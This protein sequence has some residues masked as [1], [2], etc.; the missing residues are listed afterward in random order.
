V[1]AALA[2]LGVDELLCLGDVVGYGADPGRVLDTVARRASRVVAGNHDHASAGRM[3][4]GWFNPYARVAAEW[5]AE[6]LS[7]DQARYLEGLPL[8]AR[9][10]GATL[11]HSSP[12]NP[13]EWP[14]LVSP[15]DG[16]PAF[17]A[18]EGPLCF[19]GHSHLPAVWTRDAAGGQDFRPGGGLIRLEPGTRYIVNVGSVGQPRDGDPSAAFA[20][21]DLD[22]GTVEVRRVR[23]DVE[24]A[25]R[26]IH[27]AGLPQILGDRLLRGR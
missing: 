8:V 25:R 9:H 23:Y 10:A 26:R 27:A 18:F 12:R 14:Y 4:L 5:T 21:W 11:V 16:V 3:D 19:I 1:L 20:V 24:E 2:E 13:A 6:R 22:A 7:V 15:D 17:D